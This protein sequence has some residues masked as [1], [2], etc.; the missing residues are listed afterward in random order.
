MARRRWIVRLGRI[1]RGVRAG[2]K[3]VRTVAAKAVEMDVDGVGAMVAT[4]IVDRV[5]RCRFRLRVWRK[6]LGVLLQ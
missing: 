6:S 5:R 3:D 4:G 2:A 1:G